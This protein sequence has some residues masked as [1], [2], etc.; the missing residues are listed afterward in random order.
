MPLNCDVW[1]AVA[2]LTLLR[3]FAKVDLHVGGMSACGMYDAASIASDVQSDENPVKSGAPTMTLRIRSH[4]VPAAFPD[5]L[6]PPFYQSAFVALSA[7][8][9]RGAANRT[10]SARGTSQQS[11]ETP[12]RLPVEVWSVP[13]PAT[14]AEEE[15]RTQR[16]QAS[17]AALAAATLASGTGVSVKAAAAHGA[18]APLRTP[19]PLL[20]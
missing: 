11:T 19:L 7:T 2:R 9:E 8:P 16:P 20:V 10:P 14:P 12:E 18:R 17:G 1:V 6:A 4:R 13:L 5:R 3:A 15:P